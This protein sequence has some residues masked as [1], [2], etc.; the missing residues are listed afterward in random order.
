MA[1][2]SSEQFSPVQ[3]SSI[4]GLEATGAECQLPGR[5]S[6]NYTYLHEHR[7][8]F[9]RLSA[10]EQSWTAVDGWGYNFVS[11]LIKLIK[12]KACGG[13]ERTLLRG[14]WMVVPANL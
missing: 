9:V 12:L 7:P 2:L 1:R 3:I 5:C 13:E 10:G 11:S 14:W 4:L 6:T 8:G